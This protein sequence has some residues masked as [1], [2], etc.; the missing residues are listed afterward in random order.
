MPRNWRVLP[1]PVRA[2]RAS[3]LRICRGMGCS[4]L[5]LAIPMW[6]V[7]RLLG[8]LFP[9]GHRQAEFGQNFLVGD[10][11]VVLQ[12]F[13]CF[14]EGFAFGVA[15]RVSVPVWRDHGFEQMNDGGK[16]ATRCQK[17]KS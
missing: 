13:V 9:I 2:Y 11:L 15:Q 5:R 17:L 1:S 7:F 4:M 6:P 14:G 3:V 12:P 8:H 10:W 16:L